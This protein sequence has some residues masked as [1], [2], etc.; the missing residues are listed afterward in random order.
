MIKRWKN[1]SANRMIALGFAGIILLGALLLMLPAA[2]REGRSLSFL[3]SL[4]TATSA[5]CVTGL[6]VA[7]TWTQFTLLGQGILLVLIQVGGLGYMTLVL[8]GSR[9]LRQRIS[10]RSR[11][12]MIESVSTERL[13]DAVSLLRYIAAGTFGIE[14]LGAALL[15]IRFVPEFGFARGVWYAIF[16]SVSA[17]CNAGFDLMGIRQPYS[18]LTAY[19]GDPLVNLTVCALILLGGLGFLV[20][21]D[22][23]NKGLHFRRY[24]LHTKIVLVMGLIL[25]LGGALLF[26]LTERGGVLAPLSPGEQ[27]LASLFQA[28]SPRTAGFNTLDLASLNDGSSLL[29]ITLMFVG[30]G[31][32]STGGGVKVTTVAVCLLAMVSYV[33]GRREVGV[34]NRRLEEEQLHRAAAGV[35]LYMTLALLGGFILLISQQFSLRDAL[36]EAF[37][38]MSTVGLSTGITRALSAG[39]RLLLI[40]M[41]FCG[42][43][44]N[45]TIL[46]AVAQRIP[47]RVRDPIEHI[48]IG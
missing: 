24:G 9:M 19:V 32:G 33:R 4:F 20:W 29:T 28:V 45:L 8:L 40:L 43:I 2:N 16:H 41:M 15:A 7:D 46:M 37:S 13:T 1:L 12:L 27:V 5:T 17:F 38:A 26:W 18:S 22:V 39:N 6:V 10:L 42:R 36:F 23:W 3:D 14:G 48:A 30:A 44:G 25:T 11:S 34:F 31:P 21:R 35:T 47:P